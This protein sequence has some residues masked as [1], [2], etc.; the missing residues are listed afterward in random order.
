[1]NKKILY[2]L[3]ALVAGST[4][5][6]QDEAAV[7][8]E[9]EKAREVISKYVETRQ[10]IARVKNEWKSYQELT[11]RR[12]DLYEREISQL[13]QLIER[14]EK[15][16]TQA[17][18]QIAAVKEEIAVLRSANDIV[19]Q[20][21]PAFEDKMREMYQYFPTPLKSKVERLVQQLGKSRNS[22]DRMAI[23]I[24]ILNEVDK[25]NSDFN[26]DSFEK[27]L[28][29]GETKLVDVIYL[30]LAVAYYADSEGSI[31]GVGTPAAG[32]WQW[33]ERNDLAGSIRMAI[34]YYNG[35]IKPAMLVDLPVEVQNLTIGN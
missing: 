34:Q 20:A 22:A 25:F 19:G 2:G 7:Q 10:E 18:R 4:L 23:L 29:S 3:A 27:K 26:F 32:D 30:G 9:I 28:P 13:S 17:E 8:K 16:T 6:A 1:M 11:Q 15:D 35:D 21:L 24:G 14:A 12:I 33:A 31:G 5:H